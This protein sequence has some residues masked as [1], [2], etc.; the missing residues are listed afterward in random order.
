MS[1]YL[2]DVQD[3]L[4]DSTDSDGARL[5]RTRRTVVLFKKQINKAGFDSDIGNTK[6]LIVWNIGTLSYFRISP[7]GQQY[8]CTQDGLSNVEHATKACVRRQVWTYVSE[9][10]PATGFGT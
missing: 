4:E 5:V 2:E 8:L 1:W 10:V 6:G 9:F 3:T 7:S